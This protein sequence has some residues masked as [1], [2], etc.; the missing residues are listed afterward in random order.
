MKCLYFASSRELTGESESFF[1][2]PEDSRIDP[3]SFLHRFLL[4]RYPCLRTGFEK[5]SWLLAVNL[6]LV[7]LEHPESIADSVEAES[8]ASGDSTKQKKTFLADGDEIAVIPPIS[9]G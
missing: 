2:L 9:G 7:D 3:H 6:E 4:P 8:G 1:D 5:G